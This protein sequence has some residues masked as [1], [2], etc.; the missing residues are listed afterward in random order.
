MSERKTEDPELLAL[1]EA[2]PAEQADWMERRGL[3]RAGLL[4]MMSGCENRCVFCANPGVMDPP[5]DRITPGER[6]TAFLEAN[7]QVGLRRLCIGG[8]E[9]TT[10]P[11]FDRALAQARGAGF[12]TVQVMT[13]GNRLAE[14]GVAERWAACGVRSVAVPIYGQEAA[15]HNALTGCDS[16]HRLIRGLDGAR[17][18]GISVLLHTLAL[19]KVLP[20]LAALARFTA[21]RWGAQLAVAPLRPKAQLFDFAA[22]AATYAE[23]EEAVAEADV[24]LVGFPDCMARDR[25]RRAAL[26]TLL[27][28]LGQRRT[29]LP[30]C[31][32]CADAPTCPGVVAALAEQPAAI[33]IRPRRSGEGGAPGGGEWP[34][35]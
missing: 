5:P 6:I 35:K 13:S 3:P 31:G 10:H 19:R 28:F 18:A 7:R 29:L 12:S 23:L 11:D 26:I 22:Q 8:T 24:S 20:G 30:G 1:L 4:F 16:Y 25:P 15:Q 21:E 9:P 27:Y 33:P 34:V 2:M 14:P 17:D 32:D